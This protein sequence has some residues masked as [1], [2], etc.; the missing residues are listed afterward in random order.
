MITRVPCG[1]VRYRG[2]DGG[3]LLDLHLQSNRTS[4]LCTQVETDT[5][6]LRQR[7]TF[8]GS[9]VHTHLFVR[10]YLHIEALIVTVIFIR[11]RLADV[12]T[13]A[14]AYHTFNRSI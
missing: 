14:Q 11:Y 3:N 8:P 12:H 7:D 9:A 5:N 2:P 10:I 4:N 1:C 6:P 13:H